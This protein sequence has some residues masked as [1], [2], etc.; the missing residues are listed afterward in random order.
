MSD[1]EARLCAVCSSPLP[2]QQGPG[3]PRKVCPDDT[4]PTPGGCARFRNIEVTMR[5]YAPRPGVR[6][7]SRPDPFV[8]FPNG[9]FIIE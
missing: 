2:P 5:S 4:S 1:Q 9:G 3:R 6:R 7:H 8:A